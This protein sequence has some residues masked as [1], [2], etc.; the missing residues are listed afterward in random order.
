MPYNE[1]HFFI[2][3]NKKSIYCV[4]YSPPEEKRRDVSVILCKPIWGERIRTH[5][6]FTNLARQLSKHGYCVITCDY[7]GDGNSGG[8][9]HEL[10]F[11]AMVES[12]KKVH[13]HTRQ[14]T[15]TAKSV[16]IGLRLGANAAMGAEQEI[17]NVSKMLLFDPV[18]NPID[19]FK[20]A[21]R[22]N[23]ANQMT[24]HK[25]ILKT[26][27][28]LINDLKANK[29][30][31]IDGFVIGGTFWDSFSKI[32]P[33]SVEMNSGIPV[34]IYSM[35]PKNR[36]SKTVDFSWITEKYTNGEVKDIEQEFIWTGWKKY[37][38]KPPLFINEIIDQLKLI[39]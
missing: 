31:N 23:L 3:Q 20:T 17:K 34:V 10:D 11:P 4:E 2:N 8:E 16:L 29:F 6:I 27:D 21:L 36:K 5:M 12:I 7:Y 18:K 13:D 35:T 1:R 33:F 32:S 37:V 19:Y 24:V 28:D 14:N 15:N 25:K 39:A 22:A 9:T 26:R 38:P 30:V